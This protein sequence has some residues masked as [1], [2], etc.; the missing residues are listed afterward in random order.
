VDETGDF[1]IDA[2]AV[3][4]RLRLFHFTAADNWRVLD[5]SYD[6]ARAENLAEYRNRHYV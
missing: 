2:F 5:R 3:D 6:G 4:N 1:G